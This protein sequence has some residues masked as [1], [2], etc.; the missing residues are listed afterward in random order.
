MSQF[1]ISGIEHGIDTGIELGIEPQVKSTNK[2]KAYGRMV[3]CRR[4][5]LYYTIFVRFAQGYAYSQ[6]LWAHTN[7]DK[8]GLNWYIPILVLDKIMYIVYN[9]VMIKLGSSSK[10]RHLAD[11]LGLKN[12]EVKSFDLPCGYTCP[13]ADKCL[14]FA[15]KKTGKITD[16]KNAQFRCYGASL[17][18]AF[19]N[20][21]ALHWNNF[22]A[23][24]N[25][26]TDA[27]T[28][29]LLAGI[30]TR[31]KVLR[32]HS[33]GDFFNND[34]FQAWVNVT[35]KLSNISFFAYTKVLPYLN[36]TR[37]DNFKMVY[38]YG[39]KMDNLL[40]DENTA[41]VVSGKIEA[42]VLG[43]E[44]SCQNHPADDYN[45]IVNKKSFGLVLHGMQPKKTIE[46]AL[47]G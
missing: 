5:I 17:E 29:I 3:L 9:I 14:T 10:M 30:D 34:Y 25:Q 35:E 2:I 7:S 45:F 46:K 41:Y 16:G 20:T 8:N 22:D 38:S 11:Y 44:L 4:L 15:D 26:N 18:C 6:K 37:P 32:I 40:Q 23:L 47:L 1:F 43:I 31:V 12:H 27:M 19:T 24:K 21:R 13:C 33:F 39:G 36:I 28:E 42:D